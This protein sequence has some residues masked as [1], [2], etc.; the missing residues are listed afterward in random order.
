MTAKKTEVLSEEMALKEFT[1][2][3]IE[4]REDGNDD[5]TDTHIK[6]M[7]PNALAALQGGFLVFNDKKIPT[8]TLQ[9]PI[10]DEDDNVVLDTI[11]F[12]TRIKPSTQADLAK[13]LDVSKE[14]LL[15]A[16]NILSYL[17]NQPIAFIDRL[18]KRDYATAQQVASVFS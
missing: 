16:L 6:E 5:V 2:F 8:L 17:I 3:L 7:Y 15:F 12:R 13:G 14:T 4:W 1:A 18:S 11:N 9:V 10:K